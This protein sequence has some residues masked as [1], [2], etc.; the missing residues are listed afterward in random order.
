MGIGDAVGDKPAV[1]QRT[2]EMMARARKRVD[3][4]LHDEM[5]RAVEGPCVDG[6]ID[7]ALARSK[8]AVRLAEMKVELGI[9]SLEQPDLIQ[10]GRAAAEGGCER[11]ERWA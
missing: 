1:S 8:A 9:D 2:V 4:G 3:Q 6:E 10:R 7:R 5:A 11:S